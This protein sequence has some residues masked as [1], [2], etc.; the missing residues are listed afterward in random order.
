M[1][2]QLSSSTTKLTKSPRELFAEEIKRAMIRLTLSRKQGHLVFYQDYIRQHG[3]E[4]LD[5]DTQFNYKRPSKI[6]STL[7]D[8]VYD[9]FG[10]V[11]AFHYRLKSG[12]SASEA[13]EKLLS[14]GVTFV[15]CKS[16]LIL[17]HY[18]ALLAMLKIQFGD[19]NGANY[20]DTLFGASDHDV[21]RYRRLLISNDGE[22]GGKFL[23]IPTQLVNPICYFLD[24]AEPVRAAK[25][26]LDTDPKA[27]IDMG[28]M[29]RRGLP[30]GSSC[31]LLNHERYRIRQTPFASMNALN[32]V[33]VAEHKTEGDLYFVF[34]LDGLWSEKKLKNV[35]LKAF[36]QEIDPVCHQLMLRYGMPIKTTATITCDDIPGFMFAGTIDIRLNVLSDLLTTKESAHIAAKLDQHLLAE[37]QHAFAKLL[38]LAQVNPSIKMKLEMAVVRHIK[39]QNP[40][41]EELPEIPQLKQMVTQMKSIA[42]QLQAQN[43]MYAP[44]SQPAQA[45]DSQNKFAHEKTCVSPN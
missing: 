38:E 15:E 29:G 30:L 5:N 11:E 42:G 10:N 24:F 14:E 40:E 19:K 32:A 33:K 17:A 36:N 37:R 1:L 45:S 21:P 18:I 34:D 13:I 3:I 2:Q 16:T 22:I 4:A 9:S 26:K 28:V 7:F 43:P 39:G 27:S 25:E 23:M 8:F 41:F 31:F 44:P 6:D 35:L 20:F 12:V